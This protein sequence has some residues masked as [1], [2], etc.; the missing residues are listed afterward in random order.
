MTHTYIPRGVCSQKIDLTIEDGVIADLSF[1]GGCNGNLSGLSTLAKGRPAEEI[2]A[3]LESTKCGSK[4]TSCPAQL[5]LAIREAL[6]REQ[7]ELV[8]V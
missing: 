3:L 7:A 6:K 8:N 5:S 4:R 2:A 1:E